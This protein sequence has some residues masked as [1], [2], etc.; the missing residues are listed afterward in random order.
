MLK[1]TIVTELTTIFA[2]KYVSL[3]FT[4]TKKIKRCLI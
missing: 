1:E 3:I 4:N 2:L